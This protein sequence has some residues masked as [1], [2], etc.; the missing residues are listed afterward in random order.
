MHDDFGPNGPPRDAKDFIAGGYLDHALREMDR[1]SGHS[2]SEAEIE[3]IRANMLGKLREQDD[4][5]RER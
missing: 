1:V 3:A 2:T 4:A 5:E